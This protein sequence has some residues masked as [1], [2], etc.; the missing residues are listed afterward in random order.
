M[1]LYRGAKPTAF[2]R[3]N[4]ARL[5]NFA[6]ELILNNTFNVAIGVKGQKLIKNNILKTNFNKKRDTK[7]IINKINLINYTN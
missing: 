4:A 7:D 6:V 1:Y 5:G 2:E 3:Y